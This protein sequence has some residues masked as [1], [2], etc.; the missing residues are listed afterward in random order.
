MSPYFVVIFKCDTALQTSCTEE[1][2]INSY[3]LP[4]VGTGQ[5][6]TLE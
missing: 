4:A 6:V 1:L 5:S 3:K 2:Y